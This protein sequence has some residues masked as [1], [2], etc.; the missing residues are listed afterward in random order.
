MVFLPIHYSNNA[1]CTWCCKRL[2]NSCRISDS[3]PSF[4]P[5]GINCC[6]RR[7][8]AG[9]GQPASS[10][11]VMAW[12]IR[13]ALSS[14]RRSRHTALRAVKGA[15]C[16]SALSMKSRSVPRVSS[17]ST[18]SVSSNMV[19]SSRTCLCRKNRSSLANQSSGSAGRKVGTAKG[20]S[21]G[22]WGVPGPAV[23]AMDGG[24]QFPFLAIF[25][26][27]HQCTTQELK[28]FTE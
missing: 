20:A 13:W 19:S 26:T 1:A 8:K 6:S 12:R 2:R 9:G 10:S 5:A 17:V 15:V 22:R 4:A 21:A 24:E 25:Q 16:W 27:D 11:S 23:G 18:L 3:L 14:T 28:L 7:R